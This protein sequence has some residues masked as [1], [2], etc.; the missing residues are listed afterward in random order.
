MNDKQANISMQTT[1]AGSGNTN[2]EDLV[3]NTKKKAN[4][5]AALQQGNTTGA[6]PAAG[7]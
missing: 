1:G 4:A 3:W 2:Y 5:N 7:A 6:A